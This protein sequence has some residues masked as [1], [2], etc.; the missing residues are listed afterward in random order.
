MSF[1]IDLIR[2]DN[3]NNEFI[4]SWFTLRNQEHINPDK[5]IP[6][7]NLGLNTDEAASVV[8]NNRKVLTRQI[9]IGAS[10]IA[11]ADQVH[12][13]EVKVVHQ[14]GIYDE[15]DGLV[16][17][18]NGIALAIQ[19]ADCACVLLGDAKNKVIGAAH[20]GWRSAAYGILPHTIKKMKLLGA[21]E[22]YIHAFVS[23]CISL[24]NFE[25]GDEVAAQFP[26][27]FVHRANFAK[28]HVDLKGFIKSQLI[29]EGIEAGH[30]LV[31]NH[32]T[33]DNENFY[34]YRR[35]KEMSGRMMGII[36]LN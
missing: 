18:V 13:T 36:K 5:L 26:D 20:A 2:P 21:R 7:L 16:T 3:L 19:V 25:V 30:I 12:E 29:D 35:Q 32:C 6:G 11:Y 9:G 14:A 33:I 17:V 22:E 31:D 1:P 28:F 27:E 4:S 24:D 23:P 10:E 8:L 15:T 34:S